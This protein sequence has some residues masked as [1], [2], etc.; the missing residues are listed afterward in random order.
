MAMTSR[1]YFCTECRDD[2]DRVGFVSKDRDLVY[3]H[4]TAEHVGV[5][6]LLAMK[7]RVEREDT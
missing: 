1:E 3:E 4:I 5:R 6:P 7:T 2:P